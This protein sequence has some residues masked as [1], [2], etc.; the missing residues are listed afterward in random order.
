MACPAGIRVRGEVRVDVLRLES[1]NIPDSSGRPFLNV[2]FVVKIC[3]EPNCYLLC[4]LY[5]IH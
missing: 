4:V 5:M 2:S 3:D 1:V